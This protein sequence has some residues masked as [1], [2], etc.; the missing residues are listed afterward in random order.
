MTMHIYAKRFSVAYGWRWI[1]ERDTSPENAAAWL[2][3]F[4]TD[5]PAIEFVAAFKAPR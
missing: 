4:R 5:E 1:V 3:V 2:H